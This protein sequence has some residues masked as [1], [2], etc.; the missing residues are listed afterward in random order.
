[1]RGRGGDGSLLDTRGMREG[2]RDGWTE[3][4]FCRGEEDGRQGPGRQKQ[5]SKTRWMG[6]VRIDWS[7]ELMGMGW[8]V[9]QERGWGRRK[10][11]GREE[12]WS[13]QATS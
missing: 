11:V 1:M 6:V 12:V 9:R 10:A 2:L 8:G 3:L 4:R 13:G 7:L 5:S